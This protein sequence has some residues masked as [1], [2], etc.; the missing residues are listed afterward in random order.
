MFGRALNVP[1]AVIDQIEAN[2]SDVT[3]KCYSVLTSW[4]ERYPEDATYHRLARALKHPAV[5]RADVADKYCGLLL[6]KVEAVA[7]DY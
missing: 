5:G 6:C 7:K 2:K 4:Q 3:E 1:D